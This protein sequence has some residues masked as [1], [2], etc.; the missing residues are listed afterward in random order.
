M[1]AIL[2]AA[3]AAACSVANAPV[4]SYP[5]TDV[6]ALTVQ[7]AAL[8]R[9]MPVL[10]F[11]PRDFDAT[12]P[13]AL[14]YLFHGFGSDQTVWFDG[15]GAD[16]VHAD[17]MAQALIDEGR[18]CP[19]VIASAF[20]ANS[21]GVDSQPA[22]DQ[23]D[24]GPYAR[25][26]AEDLLPAVETSLGYRGGATHR[27]VG[28]LSMGGFAALHV[29]L[30]RP[31]WF[32]G[33]GALSPAAFVS[34]PTDRQWL[35]DGN[36]AVNDPMLL[37]STADVTGLKVFLGNGDSD[38]GWVRDGAREIAKRLSQRGLHVTPMVVPGGHDGGTW[39]QLTGPMLE[40]LL[41]PPC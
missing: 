16:G 17:G 39:R 14:L 25:Y 37:A 34:T 6:R 15:H 31:A 30:T 5:P 18:I 23:F 33:V 7:S 40:N 2:L 32:A 1:L 26:L 20:I 22:N 9:P 11:R 10:V 4:P 13:F 27:F 35:F 19:V 21:Y 3:T 28:G 36:P 38:Y 24:H 29:A 8:G 12:R 41:A